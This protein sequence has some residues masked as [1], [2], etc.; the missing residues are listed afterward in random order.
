MIYTQ[1]SAYENA[2]LSPARQAELSLAKSMREK[3]SRNQS[4]ICMVN[5]SAAACPNGL[6][7]LL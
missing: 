1:R 3:K 5:Y 6:C 7:N 2:A 4:V